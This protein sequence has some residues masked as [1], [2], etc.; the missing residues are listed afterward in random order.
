MSINNEGTILASAS[1]KGTII[2]IYRISY[3]LFLQEF[4]RGKKKLKLIISVLIIM[5][6]F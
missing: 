6:N 1:D 2:R 3:S 4:K 5:E